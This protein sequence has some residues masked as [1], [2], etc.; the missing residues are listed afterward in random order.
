MNVT[1]NSD[2][3]QIDENEL[4]EHHRYV[5]DPGQKPLR[6]D[7]FLVN[8]ILNAS[9][10]KI[11][12]A[13]QAGNI[14]VNDKAVKPNHKVLPNDVV[15]VVMAY[16]PRETEIIPQD[17][18]INIVYEDDDLAIINKQAG[19]VVHPGHGN[20]SNTLVNALAFHMKDAELFQ[21]GSAR[22]GLVHRIDK[23]TTGLLVIAKT[24]IAKNK[25][26]LQFYEKTSQR[27]Y[28]A[29]VWGS[30][31][32]DEGTIEGHIGRSSKDRK[33]MSVYPDGEFGKH[34]ITHYKVIRRI[35]YVTWVECTLET[36]RTHQIRAHFKHI[37]HPLFNDAR[38]N[39]DIILK[40][41]TFSKYAQFVRNCFDLCPR[42]ALHA[43]TLGF[44]H[45][46]TNEF[47]SFDSPL[48]DDMQQ[49]I[50]RWERYIS[51]RKEE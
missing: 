15:R 27:K 41:T 38:Y 3:E 31:E 49:L 51:R 28:H 19:M 30:L 33:Q 22:P 12:E 5:A 23:D 37:G 45:P 11:Q 14:W 26:A 2:L 46:T 10:S 21:T 29:V 1:S 40:G 47:I 17:I 35:G 6:V 24:E 9:R 25:L 39:G 34:A 50:E 13:A 20:Y 18:P 16:P 42:Q 4:F 48:P 44:V 8:K 43:K 7:K 32:Q 36:G